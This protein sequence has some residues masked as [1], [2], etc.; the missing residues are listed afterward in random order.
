MKIPEW[1]PDT[2]HPSK[3]ERTLNPRI[4][5]RIVKPVVRF[6]QV[7]AS[8]GIVLLVC[9][10]LALVLANSAW[11]GA[12]AEFWQAR[13]GF[14]IGLFALYKPLLLWI[15]DGLMTIFFFLVGLEIKR[16]FVFGELQD[17]R[18]AALPAA[19]ALGGMVV[20]AALYLGL[21]WGQPGERGWGIPMATD[22]A[23]V[24][25]FLALLGK[26]VPFSLKIL[27]LTLAIV[28]DI[29]AV[30]VIAIAYTENLAPIFLVPAA[31]G[32]AA[33]YLLN[34]LGV[35]PVPIYFILG[36]LIWLAFLKSGIHPTVAGVLLGLLTPASAWFA[37]RSLLNV[38]EGVAHRLR[39]DLALRE[40][41]DHHEEAVQLLA[42]TSKETISPLDRLETALHPWVAFG[43]MPLFALANAGVSIN[44][45]ALRSPIAIAV[46]V[47][48]VAGKPI[49]ILVFSWIA[50]RLG[51][52]RLP[53]GVT[54]PV[55]VG[56]G[57]L[58]GIG[59][60]MSLFIAG[61]GLQGELL[62]AGKVGILTG[63]ILSAAL[64]SG[65]LLQ[66][67]SRK[68][69]GSGREPAPAQEAVSR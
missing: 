42:H 7:E 5:E 29:G 27:L 22:I 10:V 13:V 18:K 41:K 60:T 28:D 36:A 58:A 12:F 65:L 20:P 52:A 48:L 32:F 2:H 26:R 16:E 3:P 34:R 63:S 46:A 15:N 66:F 6:L 59:F 43:I 55:L 31:F 1:L 11:S 30:L 9:T 17:R 50:V 8:G 23:F 61:L 62:D 47:G 38:L 64:G 37:R 68:N 40:G 19:A 53:T 25:G 44:L 21:Q 45:E 49:G 24:V 56:A 14:T 39:Q 51:V 57:C 33:C 54:W 69:Q 4:I 67:S 35:R